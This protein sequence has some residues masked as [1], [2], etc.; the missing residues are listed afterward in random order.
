[1][2]AKFT[3]KEPSWQGP[4]RRMR[5]RRQTG[6]RRV[7]MRFEFDKNDRRALPGRRIGDASVWSNQIV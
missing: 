5:H 4:E 6:D 3:S 7:V 2:P 1:M